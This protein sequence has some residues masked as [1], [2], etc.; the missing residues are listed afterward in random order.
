MQT[1]GGKMAHMEVCFE[2]FRPIKTRPCLTFWHHVLVADYGVL[3]TSSP[4]HWIGHHGHLASRCWVCTMEFWM[5]AALEHV[6]KN[7]NK[8]LGDLGIEPRSQW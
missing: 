7:R 8:S 5:I 6:M 1:K 3:W 2:Q 4:G